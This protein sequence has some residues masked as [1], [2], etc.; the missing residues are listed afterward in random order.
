MRLP[1]GHQQRLIR[2]GED[3]AITTPATSALGLGRDLVLS[4]SSRRLHFVVIQLV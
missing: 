1:Q 3:C 4:S 2:P